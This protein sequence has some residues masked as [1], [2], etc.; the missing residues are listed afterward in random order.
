MNVVTDA[1]FLQAE[2]TD[3]PAE[4]QVLGDDDRM[5]IVN[6]ITKLKLILNQKI[7]CLLFL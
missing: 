3:Q 7:R 5:L 6:D 4:K 2:V 1:D